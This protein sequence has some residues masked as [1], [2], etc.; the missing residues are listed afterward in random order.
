M[1]VEWNGDDVIAAIRR[2]V[3]RRLDAAGFTLSG[4]AKENL[5]RAYPP[6]S[7]AGEYPA[8]RTGHLRRNITHDVDRSALHM[9]WGTNVVYGK[10]LELGTRPH[11]ITAK[12]KKGLSDGKSFFGKSVT[13]S[14]S[15]RPWMSKTN[16]Q[17]SSKVRSLLTGKL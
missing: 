17:Q 16:A 8:K 14:M 9:R 4:A 7:D 1:T 5:S 3:N 6:A 13:V 15:P 12:N 10:Y 2:D 11:K